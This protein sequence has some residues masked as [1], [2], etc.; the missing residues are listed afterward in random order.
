MPDAGRGVLA[1]VAVRA[2]AFARSS[3]SA[4]GGR[5]GGSLHWLLARSLFLGSFVQ[6]DPL[7]RM[8]GRQRWSYFHDATLFG[9]AGGCPGLLRPALLLLL[10][11]RYRHRRG[12]PY[13]R[14]LH[15]CLFV[16]RT[17]TTDVPG[18]TD[19]PRWASSC[20]QASHACVRRRVRGCFC[21]V[22][23]TSLMTTAAS[24][25]AGRP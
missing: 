22:E 15:G 17:K 12:C 5:E 18:P 4:K 8:V 3:F 9:G 1:A 10:A 6:R 14:R 7:S 24:Q 13:R 11:Y 25:P 21:L 2:F 19:R 16:V 20:K 23:R